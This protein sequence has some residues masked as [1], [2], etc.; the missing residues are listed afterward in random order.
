M[1]IGNGSGVRLNS[2]GQQEQN[3]SNA[4]GTET[5]RLSWSNEA[6]WTIWPS[7]WEEGLGLVRL[8]SRTTTGRTGPAVGVVN[9][10]SF[11]GGMGDGAVGEGRETALT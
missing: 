4:E 8:F 5:R 10:P 6:L 2:D 11:G 9:C 1:W 7:I 3:A